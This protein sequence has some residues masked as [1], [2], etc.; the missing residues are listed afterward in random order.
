[1][2]RHFLERQ[3]GNI[4]LE[5]IKGFKSE[6]ERK[7]FPSKIED[8][9]RLLPCCLSEKWQKFFFRFWFLVPQSFEGDLKRSPIT[10]KSKNSS[11]NRSKTNIFYA[12]F[13]KSPK[14]LALGKTRFS[15][16]NPEENSTKNVHFR[17]D[18]FGFFWF[19]LDRASFWIT[20]EP[21]KCFKSKS[22]TKIFL[23]KIEI[24]PR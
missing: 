22:E 11:R 12:H 23:S 7:N 21:M 2:F 4:T 5:P 6:S 24:Y 9:A 16:G 20:L 10:I 18:S 1:M 8:Y 13:G 19:K 14:V 15:W 17:P 3:Q